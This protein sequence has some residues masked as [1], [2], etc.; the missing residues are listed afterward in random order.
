MLRQLVSGV[1]CVDDMGPSGRANPL[2][3]LFTDALDRS[4]QHEYLPRVRFRDAKVAEI[5]KEKICSRSNI[6][7]KHVF[8][9]AQQF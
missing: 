2:Q 9:G 3:S 5:N 8:P 6:H 4:K 7:L 1:G